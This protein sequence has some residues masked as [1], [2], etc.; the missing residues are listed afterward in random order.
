MPKSPTFIQKAL[1]FSVHLFTSSGIIAAILAIIAISDF[2]AEGPMKLRMAM[3][4]L[5][6]AFI[7]DAVDGSFARLFKAE[8]TLP[9]WDGKSI[10]YVIDFA[11]YAIIPAFFMYECGI[12]SEAWRF[13]AVCMVLLVS[14]LYY[15][16]NGM[17]SND[18]Y[19]IGFPVMWNIVAYTLYFVTD[20]SQS[21]NLIILVIF[22][23]LHFVPIKYPYPS[24]K[25]AMMIPSLILSVLFFVI[26]GMILYQFP[27]RSQLLS[28]ISLGI[29]FGFGLLSLIAS[30]TDK[31]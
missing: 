28:Y 24:R 13:P 9:N 18:L 10:D 6:V 23:I 1:A 14:A 30:F 7:I 15:G 5:F 3:F 11:T 16:K 27:E 25:N 21:A 29:V 22:S 31:N 26:N 8:E 2:A 17:V 4:W 12:L 20:F 19:F